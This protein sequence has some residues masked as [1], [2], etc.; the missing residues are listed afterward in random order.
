[1]L[2]NKNLP[3]IISCARI[4]GT[5]ALLFLEPLSPLFIVLYTIVG[6]TDVL[7]GFIARRYGTTSEL[8]AKLDSI[9]DLMFYT[10]ILIRILPVMTAVLP[11][12]IW[13]VVGALLLVRALGY[14]IDAIKNHR[15]ASLHTYLN[16][17]TGFLV[18]GIVYVILTPAAVPYCWVVCAVGLMASFQE[19]FIHLNTKE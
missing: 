19:L 1:M 17:A 2:A 10:L 4:A 15:F 16:K 18:F 3:N 5:V 8:G 6:A 12:A 9:A 7:D 13:Y 11:E 14:A